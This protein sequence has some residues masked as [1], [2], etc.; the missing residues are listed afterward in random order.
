MPEDK[1]LH[2]LESVRLVR[3]AKKV[4]LHQLQS[5]LGKLNFV[6]RIITMGRVFC[7]RLTQATAWVS[8]LLHYL[9]FLQDVRAYLLVWE[10]FLGMYNGRSMWMAA[11]VSSRELEL[12]VECIRGSR[13]WG[14]LPVAVL[15]GGMAGGLEGRGVF[16]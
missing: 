9:R 13:F 1:L 15:R 7:W 16:D 3:R 14:V 12:F 10:E 4:Q 8:L 2:L 6:C 5:L 11:T